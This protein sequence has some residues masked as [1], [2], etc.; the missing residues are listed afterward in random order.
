M[1]WKNHTPAFVIGILLC[2]FGC[3]VRA[4]AQ[5]TNYVVSVG[6]SGLPNSDQQNAFVE[7]V[8]FT[9][10]APPPPPDNSFQGSL[11][12]I[13]NSDT[14]VPF[15]N[16]T[17][18]G[19]LEIDAFTIVPHPNALAETYTL[20]G[21]SGFTNTTI[22]IPPFF[23]LQPQPQSVFVGATAT[24]SANVLHTT[25]LQW[26]YNGSNLVEDGHYFGVTNSVL[27]ISN[28]SLADAGT[29]GLAA[30]HPV[31]P[32]TN[33]NAVLSVFKPIVLSIASLSPAAVR[34][35]ASNADGSPFEAERLLNISLLAS[36][37]PNLSI[38]NWTPSE[39]P[40]TLTNGVLQSDFT[41]DD[42]SNSF[43]IMVE[44]P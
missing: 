33:S 17:K 32:G 35:T 16:I 2:L 31:L 21:D 1:S 40:I 24:F 36:S 38:S 26:Q 15:I 42:S 25:G 41:N 5:S 28:V 22:Q 34:L 37:V 11:A 9:D 30:A 12:A 39:N 20:Y 13:T 8:T 10:N 29:Y 14:N 7:I 3:A 6:T 18:T 4:Q 23:A 19:T 43:W 27:T 44:Q